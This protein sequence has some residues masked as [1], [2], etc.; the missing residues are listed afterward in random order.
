M[1]RSRR[2]PFLEGE[3]RGTTRLRSP[4]RNGRS[5]PARLVRGPF[6]RRP[7]L[8]STPTSKGVS[9]APHRSRRAVAVYHDLPARF[10]RAIC[11][12]FTAPSVS[13]FPEPFFFAPPLPAADPV[14]TA[15]VALRNEAACNPLHCDRDRRFRLDRLYRRDELITVHRCSTSV[16]DG[17]RLAV[18]GVPRGGS[19]NSHGRALARGRVRYRTRPRKIFV[20]FSP[21][22]CG[23]PTS[24]ALP[25]E[26]PSRPSL[27]PPW[28]RPLSSVLPPS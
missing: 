17:W 16:L 7:L 25:S 11:R 24:P 8:C 6:A 5:N 21:P 1:L 3:R 23:R 9:D 18:E 15:R 12:T 14:E 2:L 20:G 19:A 22:S 26:L 4:D 13:P 28:S 10:V 27:A